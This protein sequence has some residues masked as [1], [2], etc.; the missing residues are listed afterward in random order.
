MSDPMMEGSDVSV[1]DIDK[2]LIKEFKLYFTL[3]IN[4]FNNHDLSAECDYMGRLSR[5]IYKLESYKKLPPHLKKMIERVKEIQKHI[6]NIQ[7]MEEIDPAIK[8]VQ[9]SL[10][11]MG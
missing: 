6:G 7:A 8:Q 10:D 5:L 2:H 1:Q 11:K 9:E 3:L 4:S